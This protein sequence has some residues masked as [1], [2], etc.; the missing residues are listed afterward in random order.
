MRWWSGYGII[1]NTRSLD[2]AG[3]EQFSKYP[4]YDG[5]A[6]ALASRLIDP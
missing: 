4:P 3:T 6:F 1:L 5:M 2:T